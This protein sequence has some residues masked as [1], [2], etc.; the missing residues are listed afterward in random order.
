[1]LIM[2]TIMAC[3]R[4]PTMVKVSV[5]IIMVSHKLRN[6]H[7]SCIY[8]GV[9][10]AHVPRCPVHLIILTMVV[11]MVVVVMRTMVLIAA[12]MSLIMMVIDD[13]QHKYQMSEEIKST[14]NVFHFHLIPRCLAW[15]TLREVGVYPVLL[16]R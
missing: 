8:V 7:L 1:M 3:R 10:P 14:E 15:S 9:P 4:I 11:K 12:R 2:V 13:V 6:Y 5:M 16:D